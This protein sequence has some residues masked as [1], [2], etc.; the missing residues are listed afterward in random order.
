MSYSS[1][2]S[3]YDELTQ[4][5]DYKKRAEYIASILA[6]FN[7]SS[8]CSFIVSLKIVF[9]DNINKIRHSYSSV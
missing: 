5:V 2:A 6:D 9:S 4:N 7:I 3:V 1:F 8:C